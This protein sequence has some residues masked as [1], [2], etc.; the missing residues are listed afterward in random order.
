MPKCPFGNKDQEDEVPKAEDSRD[1][2]DTSPEGE[3]PKTEDEHGPPDDGLKRKSAG[4]TLA[5]ALVIGFLGI[6]GIGHIY[7]GRVRRGIVV[8]VA[9]LGIGV[10]TAAV[11]LV[12][13]PGMFGFGGDVEALGMVTVFGV[14]PLVAHVGFFVWTVCDAWKL[15]KRY[16]SVLEETGRP[17][18]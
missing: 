7:L 15:C 6:C 11:W 18:W 8:L 4:A 2:P 14:A 1:E 13:V 17:P 9:S 5:L 10:A 3:T 12:A 16:N